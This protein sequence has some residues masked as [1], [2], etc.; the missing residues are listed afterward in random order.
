M[1]Q[2]NITQR[3]IKHDKDRIYQGDILK[4]IELRFCENKDVVEISCPYVVILSQDCDLLQCRC[5][6]CSQNKENNQ[7]LP[8][9]IVFPAFVDEKLR[10]G[11]HLLE[12][13][14][15]KQQR[16]NSEKFKEIKQN[17]NP[18]YHYL[19]G[20]NDFEL[21]NLVIDFKLYYTIP[22]NDLKQKYDKSYIATLNELFREHLSQR[23]SNYLSRIG[24]PDILD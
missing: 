7:Y 11:N 4:N 20:N 10:E 22:Y 3:Y 9:V 5:N 1:F 24:L 2:S 13:Y 21:A 17:N 6:E 19:T 16:I 18:R 15:V 14:D 12:I 8:N 23:F